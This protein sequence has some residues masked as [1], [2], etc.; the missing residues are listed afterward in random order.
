MSLLLLGIVLLIVSAVANIGWLY[1]AAV[2]CII[3]GLFQWLV[4]R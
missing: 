3:V 4:D 1:V 2:V